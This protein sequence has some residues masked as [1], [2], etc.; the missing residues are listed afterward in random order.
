MNLVNIKE[1]LI[2]IFHVLKFIPIYIV[3]FYADYVKVNCHFNLLMPLL[4]GLHII[5]SRKLYLIFLPLVIMFIAGAINSGL[6]F[7]YSSVR[8][9][10]EGILM[11]GFVHYLAH[12]FDRKS[13][14]KMSYVILL[15]SFIYY[16]VEYFYFPASA[17]AFLFD[18]KFP[19]QRFNGITGYSNHTGMLMLTLGVIFLGE[20]KYL[21][22]S[23]CLI[24]CIPTSS[25][26]VLLIFLLSSFCS[27]Y[28]YLI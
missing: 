21:G 3:N 25:R 17:K 27:P 1:N 7:N 22:W 12:F 8:Y 4:G 28:I 26:T 24:M 18:L 16:V 20:R 5:H 13:F 9:S 6:N 11:I 23:L 14:L 15:F 10:V 2:K 19:F